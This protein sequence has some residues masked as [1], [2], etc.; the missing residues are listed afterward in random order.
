[1]QSVAVGDE[2]A[3]MFAETDLVGPTAS[4]SRSAG[5]GPFSRIFLRGA[6][7]LDG[8]GA[9]PW[10]PADLLIV[11]GRISSLG[12]SGKYPPPSDFDP[13]AS[14]KDVEI[15]CS[16]KY[17][18]PG[19]VDCHVHIAA[20]FHA[21]NGAMPKADYVYKLWLAHGVTTVRETG[22]FN[23]L[24]WTLDQKARAA[25]GQ[26]DAPSI[27]AYAAF[28]ATIDYVNSIHTPADARTWLKAVKDRGADGV[29]F[30]GAPPAIMNAALETCAEIGLRSCCHHAQLAV[31]RMNALRT[32]RWGLTSTEHSYGIPETLFEQ[33][34]LYDYQADHT[35]SDEYL[36]FA[37]SGRTFMQAAK[38]GSDRWR[39]V[40]AAFLEAGHTFVPTF[41][42]YDGNRDLMRTRRADWHERFTDPTLWDYFQPQR[43]GHATYWY[44]WST[45]NEIDW[46]ETFRL[47][48]QF[49][50]AYKNMGGRIG[51][52]SDSG[53]DFQTYGFGFIRELELLQ[54]AGFNPLEVLRAATVSGAEL[55]GIEDD[56]GTIEIGKRGDL[57]IHELNPLSDFKTL[58]GTGAMRLN[59]D[60]ASVEWQRSIK[61]V[62]KGGI[63]YDAAQLLSDIEDMVAEAKAAR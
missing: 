5:H 17:L 43:G 57:V 38:P 28:P 3:A 1:M 63:I 56:V 59:D 33:Q 60:T 37:A 29:K 35:H 34:T 30:F 4:T 21:K 23:G 61:N 9:P 31:G 52:G 44:R 41:S 42:V 10:G 51:V 50:N 13:V 20:P 8:T 18:T 24:G 39:A 26:I 27:H 14:T 40:L 46:R 25:S 48:M 62:I 6:M 54:E 47:W 58:Y 22:C 19:F 36:R 53:F 2:F 15:D 11:D 55:L 49:V 7:I 45:T 32:A 12:K 16:G